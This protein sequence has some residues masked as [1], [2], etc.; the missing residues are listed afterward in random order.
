MVNDTFYGDFTVKLVWV[1]CGEN[2]VNKNNQTT[3]ISIL[4]FFFQLKIKK[5][6]ETT[7]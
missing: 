4:P 3:S 2:M 7:S 1:S 6:N 5:G